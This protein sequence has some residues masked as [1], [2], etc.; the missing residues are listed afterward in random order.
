METSVVVVAQPFGISCEENVV[1][2]CAEEASIP[3]Q[4]ACNAKCAGLVSYVALSDQGLKPDVLFCYDLQ[5]P[6]DFVPVPQDGEVWAATLSNEPI[7]TM[8][9]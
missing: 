8:T 9:A 7:H 3:R 5:L 6:E 2:E 4:L 1:K